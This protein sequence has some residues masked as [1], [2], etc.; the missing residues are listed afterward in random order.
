MADAILGEKEMSTV[1]RPVLFDGNTEL[2]WRK[3][4]RVKL[5]VR[6]RDLMLGHRTRQ[7]LTKRTDKQTSGCYTRHCS[8]R[9]SMR[10]GNPVVSR[11]TLRYPSL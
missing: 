1:R 7:G 6:M 5:R 10:G 9:T 3:L 4:L 8:K 11:G 2:E